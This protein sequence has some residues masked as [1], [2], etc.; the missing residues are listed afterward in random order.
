LSTGADNSWE[1]V[2]SNFNSVMDEVRQDSKGSLK[3]D[4]RFVK[5]SDIKEQFYCEQQV[6]LKKIHGTVETERTKIGTDAH[7]KLLADSI[8]IKKEEAFR[9][10]FTSPLPVILR[11]TTVAARHNDI[12]IVGVADCV[13][14]Y[15]SIPLL[16]LDY[17]FKKRIRVYDDELF[18]AGLYSYLLNKMGFDT[19][20]L[21]YGVVAADSEL[22]GNK[23][24]SQ[25][26]HE[27][28]SK[29]RNQTHIDAEIE[30][31]Q[32]SIVL[33]PL[34]IQ[35]ITKDLEWA[36]PFWMKQR[37]PIPTKMKAKCNACEFKETCE[38]SLVRT[39]MF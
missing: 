37:D 39:K 22:R 33:K 19:S 13:I 27:I 8:S 36:L 20:R 6:E 24:L 4:L 2:L 32:V 25:I 7:E 31:R 14:F 11:E 1:R 29:Y 23:Q 9:K 17:K 18:Q 38:Y 5:V 10:I 30:N 16:L 21:H 28:I 35:K 3:F 34:D 26:H 15:K 12:A